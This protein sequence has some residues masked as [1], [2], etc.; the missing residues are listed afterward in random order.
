M[1]GAR[2]ENKM[3]TIKEDLVEEPAQ[4]EEVATE[5]PATETVAENTEKSAE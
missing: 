4:V 5:A 2:I 1:V 3:I